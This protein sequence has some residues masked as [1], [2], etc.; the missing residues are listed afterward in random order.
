VAWERRLSSAVCQGE[1][2]AARSNLVKAALDAAAVA[3]SPLVSAGP[4]VASCSE[5][6]AQR[7]GAEELQTGGGT[8]ELLTAKGHQE[9]FLSSTRPGW[10]HRRLLLSQSTS[11]AER[12]LGRRADSAL[13]FEECPGEEHPFAAYYTSAAASAAAAAVGV[14]DVRVAAAVHIEDGVVGGVSE[15]ERHPAHAGALESDRAA[16]ASSRAFRH[17]LMQPP[18]PPPRPPCVLPAM[19]VVTSLS[20]ALW[21]F[22]LHFCNSCWTHPAYNQV[23]VQTQRQARRQGAG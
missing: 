16:P 12:A 19:P 8:Q 6:C 7:G 18:A 14:V 4:H 3:A 22:E 2:G 23:K 17:V 1:G 11:P 13:A 9:T 20:V 15:L 5:Y 10:L 21:S